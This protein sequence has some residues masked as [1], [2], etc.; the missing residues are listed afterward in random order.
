MLW[1]SLAMA[2]PV[3]VQNWNVEADSGPFSSYGDTAQWEWGVPL[4]QPTAHSGSRVWTTRLAG[5]YLNDSTDYL[6]FS[7]PDLSTF[8]RPTLRFWAW[9]A[10]LPGDVGWIELKEEGL[11][12][13]DEPVYG[14]PDSAGYVGF[15]DGWTPIVVD[16]SASPSATALRLAFAADAAGGDVGWAVDDWE[17]W[18]GDIAAPRLLSLESPVDTEDLDGPYP[19]RARLEDDV[20]VSSARLDCLAGES[21]LDLSLSLGSDGWWEAELPGQLPNTTLRCDLYASDGANE[22][23]MESFSFRVYLPAPGPISGPEG[24][25]ISDTA[26][27]TW[28]APESVHPVLG[29][30]VYN[31]EQKL[32]EVATPQAEVPL[33]GEE[34][35]FVVRAIY[36]EGEGD[37]TE[38]YT[39]DAVVPK[40][41]ALSPATGWPGERLHL[42]LSG[43]YLFLVDGKVDASFERGITI[44][45]V[46]VQDVDSALLEVELAEDVAPGP[47]GLI[48]Q[49]S[50]GTFR[51]ELFTV[52]DEGDRPRIA[53]ISPARVTQGERVTLRLELVGTPVTEPTVNLGE[54]IVVESLALDGESLELA[55]VVSP[56]APLGSRSVELDDGERVYTGATLE[57]RDQ[58]VLPQGNCSSVQAS[59]GLAL[60]GLLALR[61]RRSGEGSTS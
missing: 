8:S 53:T 4:V 29:Y 5:D 44:T 60:L 51:S 14:Y 19:V 20:A 23:R 31:G 40:I 13:R 9:Y 45:S 11:W 25:L 18:D 39:V 17:L 55:V 56:S 2:A 38:V 22:A 50:V 15:S 24:R 59:P 61:R 6:E 16:L 26:A 54:G 7:L 41:L 42:R 3:F 27:L 33:D 48:L 34:D 57:V 32:M 36:A 49:S 1:L 10:I 30:S 46:A 47:D 43:E 35:N 21:P 58:A 12:R 37:P 28:T 52:Q